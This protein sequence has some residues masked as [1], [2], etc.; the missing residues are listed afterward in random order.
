MKDVEQ[1]KERYPYLF[2]INSPDDLKALP[3][4]ALVPLA[5]EIRSFLIY[6]VNVGFINQFLFCFCECTIIECAV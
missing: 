2:G 6:H 4:E 1:L 5:D 3:E